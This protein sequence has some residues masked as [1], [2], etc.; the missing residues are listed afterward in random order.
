MYCNERALD[1]PIR[2]RNG[3]TLAQEWTPIRPLINNALDSSLEVVPILIEGEHRQ[4][5]E[6]QSYPREL[7]QRHQ[8]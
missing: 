1:C 4:F 8:R 3:S 5:S 2:S 6:T 7:G